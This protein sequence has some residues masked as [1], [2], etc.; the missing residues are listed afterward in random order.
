MKIQELPQKP[1]SF[2]DT[3]TMNIW[4][5]GTTVAVHFTH[6]NVLNFQT[7]ILHKIENLDFQNECSGEPRRTDGTVNWIF[8]FEQNHPRRFYYLRKQT[9]SYSSVCATML[10]NNSH[11]EFSVF[12][13]HENVLHSFSKPIHLSINWKLISCEAAKCNVV[14]NWFPWKVIIICYHSFELVDVRG[15]STLGRLGAKCVAL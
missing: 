15:K 9:I 3:K 12:W 4:I 14:I 11:V 1:E 6:E 10:W 7:R 8:D 13:Q 5:L 2:F